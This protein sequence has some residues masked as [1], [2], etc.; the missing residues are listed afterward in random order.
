[1]D[2]EQMMEHVKNYSELYLLLVLLVVNTGLQFRDIL[3]NDKPLKIDHFID[4]LFIKSLPFVLIFV[5]IFVDLVYFNDFTLTKVVILFYIVIE[6][7]E[8]LT[9][10]KNYIPIPDALVDLFR[11]NKDDNKRVK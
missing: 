11:K 5:T 9:F 6:F 10:M 4:V 2:F 8:M 3:K 7:T 1:M